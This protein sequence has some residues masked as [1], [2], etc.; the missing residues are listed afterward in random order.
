MNSFRKIATTHLLKAY[1]P[2]AWPTINVISTLV[3]KSSGQFIFAATVVKYISSDRHQPT[4]RLEIILGI[5]PSQNDRPFAELDALYMGILSFVKDVKAT[6]RLLGV[7]IL[8]DLSP[9]RPTPMVVG[10]F[11]FLDPGEVECLLLDLASVVE[12]VDMNTEIQMFHASFPDFLF[13]RSRS[14]EYYIDASMMHAEIAQLCLSHIEVH[15][16]E[17][18]VTCTFLASSTDYFSRIDKFDS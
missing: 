6:L 12:C 8:C 15:E 14:G 11:M 1:I 2:S 5:Q 4:R 13:D 16:P 9:S 7:L 18:Y 10:E 17:D 3:R